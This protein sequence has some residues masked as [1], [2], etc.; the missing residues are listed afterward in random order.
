AEKAEIP[1]VDRI[2]VSEYRDDD[3]EADSGLRRGDRDHE[4]DDD[5]TIDSRIRRERHERE[6][7]RIQHQ[8][9]AH[10]EN[11]RV[12]PDEGAGRSDR[13]EYGAQQERSIQWE[14]PD[15]LRWYA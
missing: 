1:D 14:H 6:V 10:E 9:D 2:G 11:D 13:E 12:P 3:R 7:H 4:E 15:L 8:L 5:L